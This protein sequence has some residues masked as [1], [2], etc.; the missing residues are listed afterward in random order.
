MGRILV[1][2]PE[3]GLGG[4]VS[5]LVAGRHTVT[6]Q[7]R[8]PDE[9][10]LSAP[11]TQF[12][13]IVCALPDPRATYD[14]FSRAGHDAARKIIFVATPTSAA[15]VKALPNPLLVRP[16]PLGDLTA[17]IDAM[18]ARGAGRPSAP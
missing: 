1:L 14:V 2:E 13:A 15:S 8:V 7:R 17:A 4:I 12:D 9:V 16:F 5:R 6:E 3:P 18:I 11:D 10:E